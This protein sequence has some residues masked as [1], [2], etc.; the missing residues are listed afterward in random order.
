L[1][2]NGTL[3]R[4]KN[5]KKSVK[6]LLENNDSYEALRISGDLI[7]TGATGTNVADLQLLIVGKSET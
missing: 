6:K 3:S 7:F 2:D 5:N 4:I 1:V